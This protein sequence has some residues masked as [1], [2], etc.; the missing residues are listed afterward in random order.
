MAMPSGNVV[1]SDKMQFPSGT[2]GA[3]EIS[4][5]NNRQWFP[6][7]RDGFISWLRGEFAAANAMIDSLCHHLR[8]VGEPGEYDA[9]IACIQ[10]RRCNWNPVLHMQQYFSVAEVMFALQ[11]VAW[12]RQQRFYDPVKM[13]NKEFKRSGVGFKQWQRNDSFKDGRN[14]AAES[15]CLDGNSSFGNAASEK[16]GSDKSGDEVGNSDDRGSM[17]AAKEKNDSAA[18]SQEDGNVK[19][20]G[21]FEGVVSGSEPEVH[22]VDDGCTSSSKEND[23]HS[24]PK[25]NENSNLANVPKT[26]SG[27]EMFDGKPV[28]VVE[29]LKL[30]EEFC[31]DTEV[32]KLVALVN[33]LRSA[34]ERGHFQSQT[35]VVSKRPMKG[36]G[37]EKIQLGLP[38]AD[39]PVEDEISAGTLKDRRTEAIP[40]L[41]QDVA[42]R[43]VSMQVATVK[44]DS[45]IIDF[46]NEGDHSQPHLWPSWFGRPVCVLFLTECDMTFGRVFAI[47]HPGDYRGALKLSLKPGS[48]LAMQGKSADFAKHAIPSL[49]RQRILVTFTKSQP[50]KSMPSDGQRMPSPGVAPSSHWGP[51][52]SRSPNHI[53]HPG[54]KHYAPVPTTGVLQASPVRPQ[55]P[56]PNGI[57][58]L[59]VTAPV[60]PAMPFPAP[61][62]IP[63]SSSGWSAAPPR[64][65][66]P[67]LPVPGTGVFLPPPGSGGNSSG[68]Q[69]VLGNDTNHTVETAAP[70]EKENGSG[71]LNHGMTASPKGKVDSKTQKQECNGSLDGS[72]SVI[73][74]TKEER[75]QSSDN[76]ATSK[77]AAAV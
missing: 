10:L 29:G 28:N 38:I 3:G 43:L 44:P 6:D 1:S 65:P 39:A 32:S 63:P 49:R 21:N 22:A 37:R 52:P 16:G 76:T 64:H 4:H 53:R 17:P 41:L 40:P 46:Y 50:K 55:I 20:L 33:D 67:R 58:P 42:E 69:Q 71:K 59:F 18:K 11:Q 54:P 25:Q 45:C 47:D 12:R 68:S 19:S 8:A 61:V 57:Q 7:E 56:P 77:S 72:G 70:P 23:S 2:A 51:Q 34:G 9:V 36:H 31:A 73:S 60:A 75:Q 30:Y 14:S 27:N 24:T 13:G 74:V 26:F 62:P 48:L 5:H 66:P 35:Y 15:H